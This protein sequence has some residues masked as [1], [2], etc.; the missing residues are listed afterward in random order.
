LTGSPKLG[1]HFSN[2]ETRLHALDPARTIK[3]VKMNEAEKI[4]E[5]PDWVE[6]LKR[7]EASCT[8]KHRDWENETTT[9]SFSDGSKIV[10]SGPERWLV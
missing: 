1:F 4:N 9:F 7:T 10:F 3:E 6:A 2:T 8:D 5:I